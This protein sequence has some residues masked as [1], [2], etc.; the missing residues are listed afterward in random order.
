MRQAAPLRRLPLVAPLYIRRKPPKQGCPR[1]R[2]PIQALAPP[3]SPKVTKCIKL[4]VKFHQNPRPSR[5]FAPPFL[6]MQN[7]PR[8]QPALHHPHYPWPAHVQR[9]PS[10]SLTP[11]AMSWEWLWQTITAQ[12]QVVDSLIAVHVAD[13]AKDPPATLAERHQD[14]VEQNLLGH[15]DLGV[16][17]DDRVRNLVGHLVRMA[18]RDGFG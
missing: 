5:S 3:P 15:L 12:P 16:Q 13:V 17:L 8:L 14:R 6:T 1:G 10:P 9:E 11:G 4:I 7:T 18:R 2:S